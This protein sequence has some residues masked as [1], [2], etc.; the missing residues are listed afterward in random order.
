MPT[1]GPSGYQTLPQG[2]TP[3]ESLISLGASL[4]HIFPDNSCSFSTVCPKAWTLLLHSSHCAGGPGLS[5]LAV[6]SLSLHRFR[7][8][9]G[10]LEDMVIRGFEVFSLGCYSIEKINRQ[11]SSENTMF[12][13]A[14]CLF[15]VARRAVIMNQL[16]AGCLIQAVRRVLTSDKP[17]KEALHPGTVTRKFP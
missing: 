10:I 13:C 6:T 3:R 4:G 5:H 8:N 14:G 12:L 15:Q 17:R 2:C 16:C 9:R 1:G 11:K 7:T